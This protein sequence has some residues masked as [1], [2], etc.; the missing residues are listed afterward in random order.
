RHLQVDLPAE[1]AARETGAPVFEGAAAADGAP[2]QW[3]VLPPSTASVA[4]VMYA[5]SSPARKTAVAATSSGPPTRVIA[6]D[7]SILASSSP[8]ASPRRWTS[9]RCIGVSIRPGQMQLARTPWRP[10]S[11]AIE[12]VR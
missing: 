6:Y 4:P 2:A 1:D 3:S 11:I 10:Y 5:P 7:A 12:R 8:P 9:S